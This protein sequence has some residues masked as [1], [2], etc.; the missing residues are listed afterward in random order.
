MDHTCNV[1]DIKY[2]WNL[3]DKQ[4]IE[5]SRRN[6]VAFR[7]ISSNLKQYR[8][9]SLTPKAFDCLCNILSSDNIEHDG[10][11]HDQKLW[12]IKRFNSVFLCH[13]EH[14]N[15]TMYQFFRFIPS[16]WNKYIDEYHNLVAKALEEKLKNHVKHYNKNKRMKRCKKEGPFGKKSS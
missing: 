5:I 7:F 9:V 14:A 6:R 15:S 4:Y 2:R 3:N 10:S 1:K 16:M 13:Q 12:I 8:G 11:C